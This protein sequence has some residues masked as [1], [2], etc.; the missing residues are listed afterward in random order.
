MLNYH[1]AAQHSGEQDAPYTAADFDEYAQDGI[2][3]RELLLAIERSDNNNFHMQAT[4]EKTAGLVTELARARWQL[5]PPA[6][7]KWL[8]SPFITIN[9]LL[10]I[11]RLYD[12]YS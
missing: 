12:I 11:M 2:G 3:M 1:R 8:P 10:F 6:P 7:E 9:A 4:D 5:K